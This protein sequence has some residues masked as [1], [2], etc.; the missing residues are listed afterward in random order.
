VIDV[1]GL[2]FRYGEGK[3][4]LAIAEL[5]IGRGEKVAFVGPSGSGKTTLVYLLAGILSP[6]AG[7]VRVAEVELAKRSDRELRAFRIARIGFVFQTFELLDYLTVRDNILL[8]YYVNGALSLTRAAVAA[9]GQLAASMNLGDKLRRFPKTLS[10]GE[11]QRVAICRALI[12]SPQ[13]L[14]ADEP[15]GNLDGETAEVILALL[16]R[17]VE[18]RQATLLMVTH[19]RALLDTFDRAIDLRDLAGGRAS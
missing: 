2:R 5:H 12:T 15:T 14:I 9:A 4:S 13:L 18:Q 3:F 7:S 8:P 6:H 11:K 19:N 1:Q 16:L 10:H 17:E